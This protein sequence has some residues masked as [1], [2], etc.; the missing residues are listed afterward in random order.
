[1]NCCGKKTTPYH[2][3]FNRWWEEGLRC[4]ICGRIRIPSG[5]LLDSSYMDGLDAIREKGIQ[6]DQTLSQ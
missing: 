3:T 2:K 6:F 4:K 1:M 5:R